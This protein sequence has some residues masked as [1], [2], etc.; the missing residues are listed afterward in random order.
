MDEAEPAAAGV[1]AQ[2]AVLVRVLLL[3]DVTRSRD[4]LGR[5]RPG[6]IAWTPTSSKA[7]G[8]R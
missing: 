4:G 7:S 1:R 3:L 8:F 2:R 5:V 6:G